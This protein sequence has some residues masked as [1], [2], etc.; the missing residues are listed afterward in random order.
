MRPVRWGSVRFWTRMLAVG[1]SMTTLGLGCAPGPQTPATSNSAQVTEAARPSGVKAFTA[2]MV[3]KPTSLIA[4]MNASQAS[5]PGGTVLQNLA[6]SA[7]GE[8]DGEGRFQPLLAENIPTLEN[9][10]W[11]LFPDGRMETTWRIK[12]NVL[13]HDGTPLT[14]DDLIFATVVDQDRELPILRPPDYAYIDAIEAPD[15]RTVLVR[16]KRSYIDADKM[17]SSSNSTSS[18]VPLPKHLLEETYLRDKERLL[19]LPYWSHE[20]IGTGPFVVKEFVPGSLIRLEANDRYALGRPKID[21]IQ[22]RFILDI[23]TLMT[24][25]L[26]GAVDLTLGRGLSIEHAQALQAQGRGSGMAF[27]PGSQVMAYPQFLN[28]NPAVVADP[29]FRRALMHG[30]DRA[31]LAASIGGGFTTLIPHMLVGPA[32]PEYQEVEGSAIRYEYDPRRAVQMIETLG[33]TRGADGI[34]RD[35]ANQR[36]AVELR[37]SADRITQDAIVPVAAMWTQLGVAT[38]PLVIP[39]QRLDDREYVAAFPGFRGIRQPS[40]PLWM[41]NFHSSKT[42]LPE[43]RF[44]GNNYSRHHSAELDSLIDRY[45]T[46]IPW[47][48]RMEVLREEVRYVSDNVTIMTLF[49]DAQIIFI[50]ERMRNATASQS[51]LTDLHLWDVAG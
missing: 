3:A 45:L 26:A 31:Q 16:W 13:W 39:T 9:G 15:S 34:F 40:T 1:V 38:E 14:A 36:L 7:L 19:L 22:V 17:F 20:F 46:T 43:N 37:S 5:L 32:E 30:T 12:P 18:T 41:T 21:Q 11:K 51:Q 49:F 35:G 48:E 4:R 8:I 50:S 27:T 44:V 6:H 29:Q 23:N 24:N 28:P 10:L 25:I 2:A 42:P 47:S 33:Y